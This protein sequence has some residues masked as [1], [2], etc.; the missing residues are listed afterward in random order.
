[1]FYE[2]KIPSISGYDFEQILNFTDFQLET[3]HDFIQSLF[4]LQ[5]PGVAK[6]YLL[7]NKDIKEFKTKPH[8]Q[9]KVI[10]ALT[11]MIN[12][13]GYDVNFVKGEIKRVLPINRIEHGTMIGLMSTHN[14]LRITRIIKFL[15]KID[16]KY[17]A[18]IFMKG[19]CEDLKKYPHFASLAK[20]S[21][22]YWKK[23][24]NQT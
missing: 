5:E 15:N 22:P 17:Y 8:L 9:Q 7:T 21:L 1:M 24:L 16:M 4:P 20:S 3:K 23:A 13:Y 10:K 12:F 6:A 2:G 14:Y 18:L 11:R 19:V